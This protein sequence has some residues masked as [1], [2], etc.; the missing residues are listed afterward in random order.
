[1]ILT[2]LSQNREEI[3]KS[4]KTEMQTRDFCLNR[5]VCVFRYFRIMTYNFFL[6]TRV[7]KII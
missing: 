3:G 1:M 4:G 5:V 6:T 7:L 2:K